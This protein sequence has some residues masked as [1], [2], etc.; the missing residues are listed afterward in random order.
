VVDQQAQCKV[1][2]IRCWEEQDS[3]TDTSI[4]RFTLEVP[5]TGQRFGFTN[6]EALVTAL[7]RKLSQNSPDTSH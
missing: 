7:E 2:V 1:Y 5:S 3:H 4:C 6:L